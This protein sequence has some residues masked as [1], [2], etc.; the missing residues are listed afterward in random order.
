MEIKPLHDDFGARVCDIDLTGPLP[1]DL[2]E[3]L[4]AAIDEHSVLLFPEQAMTDDA[5]MA[6]TRALGEPEESHVAFGQTGEIVHIGA[7]GNVI[8]ADTKRA[9]DPIPTPVARRA[10]TFGIRIPRSGEC[11]RMSRSSTRTR[12]QTRAAIPSS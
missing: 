2:V 9:D 5:H 12:C 3:A 4:H 6:L 7:I 8:D 1:P 11:R 10:T